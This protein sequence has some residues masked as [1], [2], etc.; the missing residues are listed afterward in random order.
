MLS[1]DKK[2]T[3]RD[4][5]DKRVVP[6]ANDQNGGSSTKLLF[7]T[8]A[9]ASA[10]SA[11]AVFCGVS[12]GLRLGGVLRIQYVHVKKKGMGR[13]ILASKGLERFRLARLVV[14][15]FCVFSC[16]VGRMVHNGKRCGR[17]FLGRA[18]SKKNVAYPL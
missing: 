8:A 1:F 18:L 16:R 6:H 3:L 17:R 9:S 15:T 14:I 10:S 13:S 11:A 7:A 2:I 12:L 5:N 4:V